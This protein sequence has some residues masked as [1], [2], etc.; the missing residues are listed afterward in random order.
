[1]FWSHSI[2][3]E[4]TVTLLLCIHKH[5]SV[6]FLLTFVIPTK[7]NIKICAPVHKKVSGNFAE[8]VLMFDGRE[9]RITFNCFTSKFFM[10]S[11]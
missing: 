2:Q 5:P 8:V 4:Y 1:M 7:S 6:A 10:V 11:C 9:K 3:F